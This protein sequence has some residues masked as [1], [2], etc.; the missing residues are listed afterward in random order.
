M[1]KYTFLLLFTFICAA[2]ENADSPVIQEIKP[3]NITGELDIYGSDDN[4]G[5]FVSLKGT[6]IVTTTD[7]DGKWT[8]TDVEPGVYDIIFSKPGYDT[9]ECYGFPFPGNG[10]A[11]CN[12]QENKWA[13][14]LYW[15]NSSE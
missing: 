1:N 9:T 7:Y 4:S 2:C 5:A 15:Y 10:M 3:G 12:F 11:Y 13:T 14:E 6:N 8:L